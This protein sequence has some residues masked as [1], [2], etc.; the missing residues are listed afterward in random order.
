MGRLLDEG[1]QYKKKFTAGIS[2][3]RIDALYTRAREAGALGGKLLGAGG[4]GY[5][6]LFCDF[7]RRAK[8][9]KAVQEAGGRVTDFSFESS[10]LQTWSVRPSAA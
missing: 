2:N 8:V 3:D 9:A 10:G 6:L 1:W 4:G 5:I 7:A